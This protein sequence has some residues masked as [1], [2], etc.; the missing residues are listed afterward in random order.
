[1]ARSGG[2][3]G[4]GYTSLVIFIVICLILIGAYVPI[5][6]QYGKVLKAKQGL[7][8]AI[9]KELEDPLGGELGARA[10]PVASERNQAKYDAAFFRPFA[11]AAEKGLSYE[12]LAEL[13]GVAPAD[14]PRPEIRD[15]FD[16]G[17]ER[18]YATV[19][20][21]VQDLRTQITD[22]TN[23]N[24]R[25]ENARRRAEEE[26]EAARR[27][28]AQAVEMR[29]QAV[30]QARQEVL[31]TEKTKTE[32]VEKYKDQWSQAHAD[33]RKWHEQY[34]AAQNEMKRLEERLAELNKEVGD[35]EHEVTLLKT[36]MRVEKQIVTEGE[37]LS[38]DHI[39]GV[40]VINVGARDNVE[41]GE[42]FSVMKFITGNR[43]VK[44]GT[45]KA[46]RVDDHV[47]T[48]EVISLQPN[49]IIKRGDPVE[50]DKRTIV[51]EKVSRTQM[52]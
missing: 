32:T 10:I 3:S 37:I 50:R 25:A 44:K 19:F 43:K 30:E 17:V 27:E 18:R 39:H 35:L 2:R 16:V 11:D 1:M 22:L 8:T 6:L 24:T 4:P 36:P 40:A 21:Y 31:E 46:I 48:A 29:D 20:D 5:V 33:Q 38:A 49:E 45:L 12:E 26:A 28:R 34:E 51:Y 15:K 7:E 14:D 42:T 41:A 9:E 13:V 47:T 52:Q 23:A